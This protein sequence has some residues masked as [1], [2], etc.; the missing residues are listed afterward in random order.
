MKKILYANGDS[1]VF[2]MECIEEQPTAEESK[3]LA[4]PKYLGDYLGAETYINNS[5]NGATNEFIFRNTIF[6]LKKLEQQG[7]DPKDIFV[8]I[9]I[10][11]L[12]RIEIDAENWT[13]GG[14]A[15]DEILDFMQKDGFAGYPA[16][17]RTHKTFFVNPN[18]SLNLKI[19]GRIYSLDDHVKE[20]CTTFLWT[21]NVQLAS[22]DARIL[23]LHELLT[24]KGYKHIFVNTVHT[25]PAKTTVD[26][27]CKNFYK[28]DSET[29][30]QFGTENFP[31]EH[32]THNHFST[33]PHRE[34]AKILFE[35]IQKNIL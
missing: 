32:R 2:G 12:H 8:V 26:L 25:L 20:F 1:F 13:G 7:H 11:S 29:F 34:Y 17:Y 10:T 14:E 4:F 22:Q 16:S 23:A 24:L 31:D 3:Q 9:G 5:Y 19:R 6:D 18:F 28:L 15:L 33:I 21:D 30:W 35:Y 27:T